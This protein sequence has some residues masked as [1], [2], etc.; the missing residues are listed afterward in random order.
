MRFLLILTLF[1][2]HAVF[3]MSQ[4]AVNFNAADC[5][6]VP[7]ELFSEL[8]SGKVI[9]LCWVMPCGSCVPASLTTYN[10]VQ[11]YSTSNPDKVRMYV[12][13]D[14]ANTTCS[15][16]DSWC[17]TNGLIKTRRFS[18]AQIN[19]SD[20]GAAGMPKIVVIG[21]GVSHHVYYNENSAVVG[22]EIQDAIDSALSQST[23]LSDLNNEFSGILSPNPASLSTSLILEN[24]PAGNYNICIFNMEG[25]TVV[26]IFTVNLLQ[27]ANEINLPVLDLENGIYIV[28]I[29][30]NE[31]MHKYRLSVNR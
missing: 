17:N 1:C 27:G 6:G 18:D 11:S 9:V 28:Q 3:A 5:D 24:S 2:L 15:Q 19:M 8:D 31:R 14:L 21:G 7:H 23:G 16:I 25:K 10:V 22:S 26:P 20:Y 29:S 30:G 12:C 13:D 4:T